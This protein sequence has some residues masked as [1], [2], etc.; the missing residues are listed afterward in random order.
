MSSASDHASRRPSP[1]AARLRGALVALGLS[2]ASLPAGQAQMNSLT[3]PQRGVVCDGAGQVCYDQQGIS[4]AITRTYFGPRAERDLLLQFNNR[5]MPQDYRLSDGSVCSVASRTCWSDGWSMR[6]VN[7]QLTNQLYGHSNTANQVLSKENG[8]CRLDD[9]GL[10]AYNGRCRLIRATG[11]PMF[12]G[13]TY[14][15]R[16]TN[17][18]ELVFGNRNGVLMAF[19]GGRSW[20]AQFENLGNNTAAFRWGTQQLLVNTLTYG[21]NGSYGAPPVP[22]AA[23]STPYRSNYNGTGLNWNGA[24]E[25]LLNGLFQ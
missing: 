12:R 2:L 20:P 13:S 5:P 6:Y 14:T 25:G 4:L 1:A 11:N 22:S 21:A 10:R 24:V 17:R 16:M 18:A 23:Y 7:Q 15:V 8:Y 3:M 19:S 9:W